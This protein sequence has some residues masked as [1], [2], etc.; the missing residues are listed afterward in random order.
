MFCAHLIHT[1]KAI[2]IIHTSVQNIQT[3][4]KTLDK[5]TSHTKK[6]ITINPPTLILNVTAI[7]DPNNLKNKHKNTF[8]YVTTLHKN[9]FSIEHKK[10]FESM[11]VE[12]ISIVN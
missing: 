1:V 11:K 5:R 12:K 4:Y 10:N 7:Y 9:S 2:L 6:P 8:K 3:S